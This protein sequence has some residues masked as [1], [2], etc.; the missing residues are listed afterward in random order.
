MRS[1]WLIPICTGQERL[2]D[3]GGQKVHPTQKPEALLHRILTAT[4]N[5][6]DVVLD[7]FLGSGT[8]AAVARRLGRRFVGVER[9]SAY[10]AHARTR[11]DAV[12]PLEDGALAATQ[13]KRSEPRIP[14]G[15]L[16]ELGLIA[17]GARLVDARRRHAAV[18][19]VDGSVV[20]GSE[21]GS[22]HRMGARVQALEAC[23]GWTFWH[24][25]RDGRLEPLDAL[26]AEV[27]TRL[28]D[29]AA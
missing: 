15:T 17:P 19:R 22:I 8:S 10:A 6:G 29:A 28:G 12:V 3:D 5:P 26:R 9:D 21:S 18:V 24:V 27:R 16:I 13:P 4:S 20:V 11:I 7:P 25:E 2:K 23:N 14:F 1:D